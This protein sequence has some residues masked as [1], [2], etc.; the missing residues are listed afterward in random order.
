MSDLSRE[1]FEKL[2]RQVEDAKAEADRAQGAYDQLMER[3]K[4]EFN[5]NTLDEAK[6]L[7]VKIQRRREEAGKAFQTKMDDYKRKWKKPSTST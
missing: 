6:T 4:K 1:E 3:L 5:C 2:K 7:L